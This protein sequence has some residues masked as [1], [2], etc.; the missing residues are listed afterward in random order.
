MA[1]VKSDIPRRHR[2]YK[3]IKAFLVENGISQKELGRALN[4]SQSA[5]NQKL[6]GTG[7]DFSLN[8]VRI[9]AMKYGIPTSYF[10]E[11]FVP[12]KEQHK[13]KELS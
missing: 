8:E 13:C 9:M 3:K 12:K 7:G 6:N 10:F 4:K 5:I 11:G 2:P 1:N